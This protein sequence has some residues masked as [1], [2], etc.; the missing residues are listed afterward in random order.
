MGYLGPGD[1]T[2]RMRSRDEMQ[3]VQ[4]NC[5]GTVGLRFLLETYASPI[6]SA[7]HDILGPRSIRGGG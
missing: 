7:S 2:L 6:V 5:R 4:K 1:L 3:S